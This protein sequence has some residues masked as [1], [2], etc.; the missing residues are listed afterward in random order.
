M[1]TLET[2]LV[3][4][5]T[6]TT[7]TLGASGDTVDVP[8][9]A[10]LDV[11]GATVSGLTGTG[12]ILQIV[13][14]DNDYDTTQSGTSY[15]DVLSASG[16]T[17]E[18]AIT[19]SATSSKIFASAMI[20][21]YTEATSAQSDNRIYLRMWRKTGSGSYS[22]IMN[23]PYTGLYFYSAQKEDVSNIV[24]PF[25]NLASPSTTD[26]VTYKFDKKSLNATGYNLVINYGCTSTLTLMEIAG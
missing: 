7:L 11:T 5:A 25:Q 17:W 2:N 23:T 22:A 8:S 6:G 19:P 1:S 9:G 21:W 18:T 24:Q 4:P 16:V 20:S 15:T 14:S 10:T 3:Q 13:N 12:K 26:A